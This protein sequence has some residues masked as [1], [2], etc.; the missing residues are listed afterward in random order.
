MQYNEVTLSNHVKAVQVVAD[1][2][3]VSYITSID[4]PAYTLPPGVTIVQTRP[5]VGP[6]PSDTT[7][8]E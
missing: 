5:I 1:D 4:G 6:P 3:H 7:S 2:G 8:V